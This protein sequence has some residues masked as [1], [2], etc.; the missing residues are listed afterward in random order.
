MSRDHCPLSRGDRCQPPEAGRAEGGAGGPVGGQRIW[1]TTSPAGLRLGPEEEAGCAGQSEEALGLALPPVRSDPGESLLHRHR[2]FLGCK[3]LHSSGAFHLQANKKRRQARTPRQSEGE[4][5]LE[6]IFVD[7]HSQQ[8]WSQ[9]PGG[10]N[11]N[12]HAGCVVQ[13]NVADA[14]RRLF[15]LR[16]EGNS[17][18]C[19]TIGEPLYD[20]AHMRYPKYRKEKGGCQELGMGNRSCC[21][22]ASAGRNENALKI[23]G[24]DAAEQYECT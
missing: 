10:N 8:Q 13:H 21:K 17:D 2:T 12:V 15:G 11:A 9:R 4:N 23:D 19:L 22:R 20:C 18:T 24:S 14:D 1:S 6:Q 16:K 7:P 3:I 5:G